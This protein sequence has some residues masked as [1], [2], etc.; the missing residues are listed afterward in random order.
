MSYNDRSQ[1]TGAQVARNQVRSEATDLVRGNLCPYDPRPV[2]VVSRLRMLRS[3]LCFVIAAGTCVTR[4]EAQGTER[5][6]A[7]R[8]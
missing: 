3:A 7:R 5:N 8:R 4:T 1:V 2:V 6:V